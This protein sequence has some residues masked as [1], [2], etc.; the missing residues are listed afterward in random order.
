MKHAS[1]LAGSSHSLR[2]SRSHNSSR[3]ARRDHSVFSTAK[4][5]GGGSEEPD[6]LEDTYR[7]SSSTTAGTDEGDGVVLTERPAAESAEGGRRFNRAPEANY[8]HEVLVLRVRGLSTPPRKRRS[9][10]PEYR[11]DRRRDRRDVGRAPQLSWRSARPGT[12]AR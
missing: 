9:V 5:C 3:P 10:S 7:A 11:L 12:A 8:G 4:G 2:R 6:T 1:S